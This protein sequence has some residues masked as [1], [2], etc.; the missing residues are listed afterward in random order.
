MR[1]QQ[2]CLRAAAPLGSRLEAAE[3]QE[4][5]MKMLS[6]SLEETRK[7]MIRTSEEWYMFDVL[8]LK[9]ERPD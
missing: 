3:L 6:Y 7:D 8:D 9:P 5:E 1:E 4:A 2:C